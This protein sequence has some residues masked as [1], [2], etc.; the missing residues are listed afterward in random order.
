MISGLMCTLYPAL[1]IGS[2]L[3]PVAAIGVACILF[4]RRRR[5]APPER[6]L[7]W[8]VFVLAMVGCGAGGGY[9]G[10]LLGVAL[11][12]PKGGDLCGLFG[13]FV[14][15]PLG[16]A[17]AILLAAMAIAVRRAGPPPEPAGSSPPSPP[18]AS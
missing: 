3:S 9:L 8:I 15:G 1:M 12:C 6:R 2:I 11:A 14:T 7:S 17:S 4:A 13:V 16:A 10:T 5:H 18:A